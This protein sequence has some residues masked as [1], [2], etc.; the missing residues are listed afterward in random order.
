MS[1]RKEYAF[2]RI[3]ALL[4]L[5][6]ETGRSWCMSWCPYH[7][8]MVVDLKRVLKGCD[9][10]D[11]WQKVRFLLMHQNATLKMGGKTMMDLASELDRLMPNGDATNN[12]TEKAVGDCHNTLDRVKQ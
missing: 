4:Q 10:G 6:I 8:A 11:L 1:A 5:M 7:A 12:E 2:V 9:L 3:L